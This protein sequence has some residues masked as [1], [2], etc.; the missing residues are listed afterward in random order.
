MTIS[1]KST[2]ESIFKLLIE[3]YIEVVELKFSS[4]G[5]MENEAFGQPV[6]SH[7]T[8]ENIICL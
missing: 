8:P 6:P 5:Q 4:Q 2:P 7:V 1:T 3:G